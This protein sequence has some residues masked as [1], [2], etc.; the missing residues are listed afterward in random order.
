[1]GDFVGRDA[2]AE[3][4]VGGAISFGQQMRQQKNEINKSV[5][6]FGSHW[7]TILHKIYP[8]TRGNV[9]GGII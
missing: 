3:E 9:K 4:R 8:K 7:T 5:V 6:A 1:L 2:T